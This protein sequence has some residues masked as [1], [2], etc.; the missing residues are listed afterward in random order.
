MHELGVFPGQSWL[1][2][3]AGWGWGAWQPSV[4]VGKQVKGCEPPSSPSWGSL[5]DGVSS[6]FSPGLCAG[7]M[8]G[9]DGQ[10]GE[11]GGQGCSVCL[12]S[13]DQPPQLRLVGH[14]GFRKAVVGRPR[15]AVRVSLRQGPTVH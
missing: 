14:H 12:S 11:S 6:C 7:Q 8:E 5:R 2:G 4:K 13:S 3:V 9:R 10:S 1:A 15:P